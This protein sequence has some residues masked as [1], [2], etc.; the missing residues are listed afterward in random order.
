MS[1][2]LF[3]GLPDA[4]KAL[5]HSH[6]HEV[7]SGQLIAP[8]IPQVAEHAL[9]KK[10]VGTYGKIFHT[11]HTDQ[12]K[13]LPV[14]AP[15]LMMGFT[16]DGQAAAAMVEERDRRFGVRSADKRRDREDILAPAVAPGAD[17]WQ[18]GRA[19]QLPDPTGMPH[20]PALQE[21]RR[22]Q[23]PRDKAPTVHLHETSI[24]IVQG[25][26]KDADSLAAAVHGIKAVASEPPLFRGATAIRRS[27]R[28]L[29]RC[30]DWQR[31]LRQIE[32][33]F[34]HRHLQQPSTTAFRRL[35][36]CLRRDRVAVCKLGWRPNVKLTMHESD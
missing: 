22:L 17:A 13:E 16:S 27:G 33:E 3:K 9:M 26:L 19:V 15:Q 2:A 31:P 4:G 36:R 18:A 29:Q 20:T 25:D 6:A 24:E 21:V 7:K 28:W 1:E 8:G 10:L 23:R 34:L 35:A 30:A 32:E 11:W 5:W 14:G 12:H